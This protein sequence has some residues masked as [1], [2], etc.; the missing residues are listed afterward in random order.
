MHTCWVTSQSSLSRLFHVRF[1]GNPVS[2]QRRRIIRPIKPISRNITS[3]PL[4]FLSRSS[5]TTS[6]RPSNPNSDRTGTYLIPNYSTGQGPGNKSSNSCS[7]CQ[8]KPSP[9]LVMLKLLLRNLGNHSFPR[10]PNS[11]GP[12]RQ[13]HPSPTWFC[14]AKIGIRYK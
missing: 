13:L 3:S 4:L 6:L 14:S 11:T 12:L 7:S 10:Q 8:Q 5:Q 9:M 2:E 1:I